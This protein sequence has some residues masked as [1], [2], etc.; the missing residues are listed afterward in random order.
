M[1]FVVVITLES[2]RG[3][4]IESCL[5]SAV[6]YPFMQRLF[7]INKNTHY[8]YVLVHNMNWT[9]HFFLQANE[10]IVEVKKEVTVIYFIR[11]GRV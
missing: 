1:L 11:M 7:I 3:N 4:V 5:H 6:F 9:F 8:V 10:D 2:G